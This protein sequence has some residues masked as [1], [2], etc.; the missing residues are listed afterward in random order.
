MLERQQICRPWSFKFSASKQRRLLLELPNSF[1]RCASE[2]KVKIL[3]FFL[4]K[5]YKMYSYLQFLCTSVLP[6]FLWHNAE[7]FQPIENDEED[8]NLSD[9]ALDLRLLEGRRNAASS[10]LKATRTRDFRLQVFL[11]ESFFH[12]PLSILLGSIRIFTKIRGV[13]R[14]G[15]LI[16]GF[17]D[18]NRLL[19]KF[20]NRKYFREFSKDA[21]T[22]Q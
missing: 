3:Y 18:T 12:R 9:R 8:G 5:V 6:T 15:T 1:F 14:N 11:Q 19:W 16:N 21:S 4:Q 20:Y 10:L 17:N 2:T 13:I 7:I 22:K